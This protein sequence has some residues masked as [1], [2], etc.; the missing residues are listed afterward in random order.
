M[1]EWVQQGTV[2]RR[3]SV[4]LDASGNGTVTFGVDWSSNHKWVINSVIVA[5]SQ[6]P[7]TSPY[8]TATVYLG[9]Q[10]VGV[11]EGA[12]WTGNQDV[13]TGVAEMTCDDLNVVFTGGVVGSVATVIIEG[14]SYLWTERAD[15]GGGRA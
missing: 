3:K 14:D 11:S 1:A 15:S 2:R 8:P 6:L 7:T 10:Q 13:F 5:T 4:T 9:G 12:T